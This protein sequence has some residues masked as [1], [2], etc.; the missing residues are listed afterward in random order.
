MRTWISGFVTVIFLC[1]AALAETPREIT[2]D[3]LV[4]QMGVPDNPVMQL[5]GD[6]QYDLQYLHNIR[7]LMSEDKI[8]PVD[9]QYEEGIELTHK[10]EQQ[11]LDVDKLVQHFDQLLKEVDK[12]NKTPAKELDG[13]LVRMPGYALP[14]EYSETA[15]REMLLVP[16]IGACIHT[17]PPPANQTVYVTLSEPYKAEELYE[18]VWVTG[19]MKVVSTQKSVAY[20]DG[21]SNVESIYTLEG[22]KVEP[23]TY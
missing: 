10:L 21:G 7:Q 2:W 17:P 20:S 6:Q 22:I 13:Q 5:S 9:I 15:V 4:P 23:Y 19:R 12:R 8:S 16:D 14:L 3:D 11:G 1:G 18:A